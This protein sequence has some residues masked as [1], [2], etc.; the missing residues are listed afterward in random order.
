M[1]LTE[2][3]T[4]HARHLNLTFREAAPSGRCR[5]K[6]DPWAQ[7]DLSGSL[8]DASRRVLAEVERR[9]IEQ[10]LKEAGGNRCA[11]PR[12]C[13][14][15]RRRCMGKLKEYRARITDATS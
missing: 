1:I 3:D 13:R 5:A 9:K 6:G 2:G 10:A 11:P 15:L 4:I 12:C 8:A 14:F 7:I